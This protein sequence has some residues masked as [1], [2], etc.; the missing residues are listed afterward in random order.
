MRSKHR[1]A[2]GR[3]RV[4]IF[5]VQQIATESENKTVVVVVQ[6]CDTSR[7]A[8]EQRRVHSLLVITYNL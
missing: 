3:P 7:E 8:R 5:R 6:Q 4:A 1:S 2:R